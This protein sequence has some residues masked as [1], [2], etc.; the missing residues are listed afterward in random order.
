[1]RLREWM[2]SKMRSNMVYNLVSNTSIIRLFKQFLQQFCH[3]GICN[4]DYDTEPE[5]LFSLEVIVGV[6]KWLLSSSGM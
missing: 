4:T 3:C 2:T 5:K 6:S 1:M